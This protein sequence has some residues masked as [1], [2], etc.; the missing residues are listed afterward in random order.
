M[1]VEVIKEFA[2]KPQP[3]NDIE[4]EGSPV[5]DVLLRQDAKVQVKE[6][7]EFNSNT[8]RIPD[9]VY[10]TCIQ[11]MLDSNEVGKR[12]TTALRIAA[13]LRWRYP[14]Y[15]V[16]STMEEWRKKIDRPDSR[17]TSEEMKKLVEG[18]YTGHNGKG[19]RWGCQDPVMDAHCSDMCSLYKTKNLH[20]SWKQ[21]IWKEH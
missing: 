11:R 15:V 3:N 7:Q 6:K 12:H 13:H 5:F 14:E 21:Q 4:L 16:Y 10:H 17:F 20:L 18:C 2:K 1:D 9:P 19:Y 8:A